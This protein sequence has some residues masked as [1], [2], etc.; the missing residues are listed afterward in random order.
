MASELLGT[1]VACLVGSNW[2]QVFLRFTLATT[3]GYR[4]TVVEIVEMDTALVYVHLFQSCPISFNFS[5]CSVYDEIGFRVAT[6]KYARLQAL[7]HW[8]SCTGT[9]NWGSVGASHNAYREIYNHMNW[10][11]GKYVT[12]AT[13]GKYPWGHG[14]MNRL[15][16]CSSKFVCKVGFNFCLIF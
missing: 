15:Y 11:I 1:M 10:W 8:H 6:R 7:V 2:A 13:G 4:T 14:Y 9:G 12:K 16:V 5:F 3:K